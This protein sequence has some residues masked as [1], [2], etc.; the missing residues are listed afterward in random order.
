[1]GK[2]GKKSKTDVA[3]RQAAKAAGQTC[4][5]CGKKLEVVMTLTASGRKHMVRKCCGT[6]I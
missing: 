3:A 1:M 5:I 4:K 2:E 6:V